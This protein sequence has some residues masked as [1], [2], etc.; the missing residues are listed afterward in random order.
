MNPIFSRNSQLGKATKVALALPICLGCLLVWL[1]A[2][3]MAEKGGAEEAKSVK[4]TGSIVSVYDVV[5]S[6][7]PLS[8]PKGNMPASRVLLAEGGR[9]I[10]LLESKNTTPLFNGDYDGKRIIVSGKL[11]IAGNLLSVE[12]VKELGTADQAKGEREA[13]PPR[14]ISGKVICA[15]AL[16]KHNSGAGCDL[17]HFHRFQLD[18]G[19]I[20]SFMPSRASQPLY[21]GGPHHMKRVKITGSVYSRAK[22]LDVE[23]AELVK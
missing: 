7:R 15:C 22:L 1:S 19:A 12:S 13:G 21:L 20:L 4:L 9:V 23:R 17:G 11:I 18:R 6:A 5:N 8:A 2:E 16:S 10:H 14:V 3:A